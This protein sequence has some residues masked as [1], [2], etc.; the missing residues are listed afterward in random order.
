[1][2]Y[3][4][5]QISGGA[6]FV[7]GKM[8]CNIPF[9]TEYGN[10]AETSWPTHHTLQEKYKN[11]LVIGASKNNTWIILMWYLMEIKNNVK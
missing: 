6:I 4:N 11:I 5:F 9:Q 10:A 8:C 2:A 7:K 1:M 3:C